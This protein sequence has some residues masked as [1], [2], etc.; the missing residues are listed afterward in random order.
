MG[1][2]TSERCQSP[3]IDETTRVCYSAGERTLCMHACTRVSKARTCSAW[4]TSYSARALEMF[5][6]ASPYSPGDNLTALA[7]SLS[8]STSQFEHPCDEARA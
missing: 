3:I 4:K 6:A 5:A 8:C 1:A 2:A 7:Y